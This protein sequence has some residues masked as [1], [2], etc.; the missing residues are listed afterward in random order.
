MLAT[1]AQ[2]VSPLRHKSGCESVQDEAK[3]LNSKSVRDG[4]VF[5]NLLALRN[6][7]PTVQLIKRLKGTYS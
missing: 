6:Q 1:E 5:R 7:I 2:W 3:E 4:I